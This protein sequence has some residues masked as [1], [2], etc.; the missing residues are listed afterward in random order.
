M[1]IETSSPRR[2]GDN[3][4]LEKSGLSFSTKKCLTFYY[5]MYGS[6]MGTLNVFVGNRKIFT[7]SGNQGNKWIKASVN[8][9]DLGASKVRV[10]VWK[11]LSAQQQLVSNL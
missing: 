5:H 10:R 7:K 8:I 6:T 3:A 1:Y 11:K 2:K 9:T 4:K